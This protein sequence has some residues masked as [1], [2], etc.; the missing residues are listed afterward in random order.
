MGTATELEADA[1]KNW[2]QLVEESF[3][4]LCFSFVPGPWWPARRR[5]RDCATPALEALG[6]RQAARSRIRR[7]KSH[8]RENTGKHLISFIVLRALSGVS[9]AFQAL[10]AALAFA[11]T[12]FGP[13]GQTRKVQEASQLWFVTSRWQLIRSRSTKKLLLVQLTAYTCTSPVVTRTHLRQ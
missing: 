5:R 3:P 2:S 9:T 8:G 13:A 10:A 1:G 11:A 12:C 6:C 7:H 4:V